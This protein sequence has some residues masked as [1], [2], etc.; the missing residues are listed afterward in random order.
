LRIFILRLQKCEERIL[1][2]EKADIKFEKKWAFLLMVPYQS[3]D[4]SDQSDVLD[5]E[6]ETEQAD[7]IPVPSTRKP[8]KSQAPTYRTDE[9]SSAVVL[10]ALSNIVSQ[11]R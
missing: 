8:W 2:L 11:V 10:S 1:V 5:P 6:T 9:A 3:T 4:E 7:E